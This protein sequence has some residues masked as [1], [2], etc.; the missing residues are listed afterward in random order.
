V[1]TVKAIATHLSNN[2]LKR[3][4]DERI[5]ITPMKL[6]KLLYYV[7]RDYVQETGE[8]PVFEQFEVWQYGPVLVSVYG[9]F[10]SFGSKP[11]KEYAKDAHGKSYM[12][13][14][15][16][17]PNLSRVIDIV[18]AKHKRRTAIELSKMTHEPGSG[19]YKAYMEGRAHITLED[20]KSDQSGK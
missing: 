16:K 3:G 2:I 5:A 18:W 20:M 7:C 8:S 19:W 13:S 17:N 6:Q 1:G 11:I 12:V 15:G 14:E 9:E 10:K 4:F